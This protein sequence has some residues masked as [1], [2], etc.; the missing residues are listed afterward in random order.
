MQESW[1]AQSNP[2]VSPPAQPSS[3]HVSPPS[4][5]D[6]SPLPP[7]HSH[8]AARHT[9]P[10]YQ[11]APAATD[12]APTY[13]T[14]SHSTH[15]HQAPPHAP[16]RQKSLS[17]PQA[18]YIIGGWALAALAFFGDFSGHQ[19]G[20]IAKSFK[21]DL[22]HTVIQPSTVLSREALAKLLAIP[23]RSPQEQ[24]RQVVPQP[25][26]Q[27]SDVEVRAGAI[28]QREAYPL[29][30][31]PKTWLVVLYEGNEYA[32]YAFRFAQ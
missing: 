17:I 6:R 14:P 2:P 24:I 21:R 18:I 8:P 13:Y 27:L 16:R 32:G 1:Q 5:R 19:S 4:S 22:C 25:Y 10:P 15:H 26:C 29:A 30:F 31:D 7:R 20:V 9:P 28:A 23:E 12:Y 3:H 11:A